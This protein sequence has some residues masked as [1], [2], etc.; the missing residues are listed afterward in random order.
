MKNY[1]NFTIHQFEEID[2][3]NSHAF[4]LTRENKLFDREV[5]VANKQISGRGRLDRKWE[6]QAGNL[7]CSIILRPKTLKIPSHSAHK[8]SFLTI[9][10]LKNA[11]LAI[12]KKS[13]NKIQLKW[14]NDLLINGAK[15]SGILLENSFS[16][17]FV[18][19]AIIGVGVNIKNY[20]QNTLFKATSFENE[21]IEISKDSFLE[22]FLD[23][24]EILYNFIEK[25][26]IDEAF[27]NIRKLWLKNAYKLNETVE[28]NLGSKKYSGVFEDID[29]NG[30]MVLRKDNKKLE[31]SFGDVC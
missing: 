7:F 20:P 29:K 8:L 14:P 25:F 2:S 5:V 30:S 16:G 4:N 13:E 15:A 24:F 23:E 27:V 6:S 22:I 26:G 9:L 17:D 18:D 19:F 21:K 10:A 11:I 31:I 1:K 28:V 3:T 12:D